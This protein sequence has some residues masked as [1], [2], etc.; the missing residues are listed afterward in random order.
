M[1]RKYAVK[2]Q[3]VSGQK[4][5]FEWGVDSKYVFK[6][7]H[8]AELFLTHKFIE[9]SRK[10]NSR[11]IVPLSAVDNFTIV[12]MKDSSEAHGDYDDDDNG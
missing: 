7:D 8:I 12:E 10:G 11:K 1:I 4:F 9:V 3:T 2:L 5:S 6:A